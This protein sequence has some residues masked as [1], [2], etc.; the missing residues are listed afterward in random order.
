MLLAAAAAA[1]AG[2][3]DGAAS[4]D[5]LCR[6]LLHA[7]LHLKLWGMCLNAVLLLGCTALAADEEGV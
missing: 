5:G 1:A 7:W 3:G 6:R 4:G 2:V